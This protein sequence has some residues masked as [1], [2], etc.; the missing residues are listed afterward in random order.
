[1]K[2]VAY[3]WL[4]LAPLTMSAIANAGE[5][6][7]SREE[8]YAA[9]AVTDYLDSWE[10]MYIFFKQFRHCYD[11]SIAE[12]A[13]DKIQVLW[14]TRWRDLPR[15]IALTNKDPEF[16]KFIWSVVHSEAFPQDAFDKVLHAAR[17]L[18]PP[19]AAE[20]CREVNAASKVP[21]GG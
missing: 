16:R 11:G 8:A 17:N 4:V 2:L 9:E 10:N 12:G 21:H 3:L 6:E 15:M 1:M 5:K 7:C 19:G 20:F 14:T 13:E 18:C